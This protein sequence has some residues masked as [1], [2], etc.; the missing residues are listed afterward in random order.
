MP[1]ATQLLLVANTAYAMGKYV[2]FAVVVL[3]ILGF[4]IAKIVKKK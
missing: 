3:F 1:G 2:G 4:V